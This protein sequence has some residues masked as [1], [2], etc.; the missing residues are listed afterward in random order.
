MSA[1]VAVVK[2]LGNYWGMEAENR[3]YNVCQKA[4]RQKLFP[5]WIVGVRRGTAEDDKRGV[6]MWIDTIDT[7]AIRVN[8]KRQRSTARK[9]NGLLKKKPV[10]QAE[11][12][13]DIV[14][15]WVPPTDK[16]KAIIERTIERATPAY[17]KLLGPRQ[18]RVIQ[19]SSQLPDMAMMRYAR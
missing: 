14:N 18:K 5:E 1:E 15:I 11:Q 8:V 16:D 17:E 19:D 7:A 3:F 13:A 4:L 10:W 2:D 12:R 6:D 9:A